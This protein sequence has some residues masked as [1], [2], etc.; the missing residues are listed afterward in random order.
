MYND[1]EEELFETQGNK[2]KTVDMLSKAATQGNIWIH[3]TYVCMY[4]ITHLHVYMYVCM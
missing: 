3:V 4:I 1:D 2:A